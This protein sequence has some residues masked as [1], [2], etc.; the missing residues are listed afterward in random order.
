[1]FTLNSTTEL[2]HEFFFFTKLSCYRCTAMTL[3]SSFD[4]E[5]TLEDI[6]TRACYLFFKNF[7]IELYL[8]FNEYK[9]GSLLIFYLDKLADLRFNTPNVKY[10]DK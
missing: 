1:M 7:Y 5:F 10:E 4:Y 3:T 2:V 8:H 9:Y 6:F